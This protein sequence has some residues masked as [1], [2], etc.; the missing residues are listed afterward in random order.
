M[1]NI[2]LNKDKQKIIRIFIG[3][4][5]YE[6]LYT[7]QKLILQLYISNK[8]V[9]RFNKIVECAKRENEKNEQERD[10]KNRKSD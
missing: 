7:Y 1:F 10:N 8:D 5:I 6:S 4:K 9:K 2:A 3:E